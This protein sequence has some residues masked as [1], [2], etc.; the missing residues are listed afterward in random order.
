MVAMMS[1][2]VGSPTTVSP[3]RRR[4][5]RRSTLV[6]FA[7]LLPWI[8]GFLAFS[9]FPLLVSLYWSFTNYGLF[10]AAPEWIGLKNYV[11]MFQ[12]DDIFRKA[13]TNTV[14]YAALS[15]PLLLF[16][17]LCTALALN[18]RVRARGLWRTLFFL[19]SLAPPVATALVFK[20]MF[21]PGSGVVNRILGALGL[22]QPG[23]F[24]SSDTALYTLVLMSVWGFGGTMIIFLAGLQDVPVQL[25]EAAELDGAGAVRKLWNI[26][27][28]LI[29]PVILFNVILLVIGAVQTFAQ[30]LIVGGALGFPGGSTLL[31]NVY[32]YQ[33]AFLPPGRLGYGAALAWVM[34]IALILLTL[35]NLAMSR[36]WV[37][38]QES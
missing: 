13:V 9:L 10:D 3:R 35:L 6:Q 30:S 38:Y 17:A 14:V 32:L 5:K 22:P 31:Y 34:L 8:I 23:W 19:P 1:A 20:A 36:R 37:Y 27:L 25:Y 26:T 11:Y 18:Q 12:H 24:A 33:T 2:R 4:G 15:V 29:S 16:T 7:F 28:P 21:D